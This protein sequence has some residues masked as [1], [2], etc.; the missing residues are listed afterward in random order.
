MNQNTWTV[1]LEKDPTTEEL[2]LPIPTEVL[3]QLGWSEGTD[4]WW[5]FEDDKIVL[6]EITNETSE[7]E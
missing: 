3:S 1:K 6:K 4:L 7:P 2:L 5:E